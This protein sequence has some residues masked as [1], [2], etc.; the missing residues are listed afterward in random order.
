ML[1]FLTRQ[2][3]L[4]LIRGADIANT[5]TLAQFVANSLAGF[6]TVYH[7]AVGKLVLIGLVQLH[8]AAILFYVFTRNVKLVTSM[9]QGDAYM[10]HT[11]E[12]SRE[13]AYSR[14]LA[15]LL[16]MACTT[17]VTARIQL[18]NPYSL[19]PY[20]VLLCERSAAVQEVIG[21]RS[22]RHRQG[23]TTLADPDTRKP[24]K[25]G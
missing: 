21:Y 17:A 16:F 24:L 25:R 5:G 7:K 2:V 20:T 11:V 13:K 22:L 19:R 23:G 12:G 15:L 10:P 6:D 1:N 8:V 14:R 4:G 18:S 9:I 3:A